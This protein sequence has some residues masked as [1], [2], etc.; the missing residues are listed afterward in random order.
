MTQDDSPVRRIYNMCEAATLG[1]RIEARRRTGPGRGPLG[2]A[3]VGRYDRYTRTIDTTRQHRV[4][5]AGTNSLT[6]SRSSSCSTV[7][8]SRQCRT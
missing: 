4:P 6:S 7:K 2:E 8:L 3:S 1:V 5:S